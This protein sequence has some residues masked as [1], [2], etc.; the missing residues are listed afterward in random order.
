MSYIEQDKHKRGAIFLDPKYYIQNDAAPIFNLKDTNYN[1][2][3]EAEDKKVG[4]LY[5]GETKNTHTT[6]KKIMKNAM[7]EDDIEDDNNAYGADFYEGVDYNDTT[8]LNDN[9]L[10]V[11]DSVDAYVSEL[12]K[13]NYVKKLRAQEDLGL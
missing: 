9:V 11:K 12:N 1:N 13:Y 2:E 5:G 8:N 6:D 10:I 7:T 3:F 4:N